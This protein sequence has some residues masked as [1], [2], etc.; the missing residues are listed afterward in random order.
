MTP[1]PIVTLIHHSH[2]MADAAEGGRDI[3]FSHAPPLPVQ[4]SA[5]GAI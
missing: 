4:K 3:I 2:S 5:I 1:Q